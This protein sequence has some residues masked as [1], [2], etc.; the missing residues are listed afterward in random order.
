MFLSSITRL[1]VLILVV[2]PFTVNP[3]VI[4]TSPPTLSAPLMPAP[5]P[6]INA[7]VVVLELATPELAT[8][9]PNVPVLWPPALPVTAKLP[10]RLF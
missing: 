10:P 3:P 4:V 9:F 5:P 6:I 1:V 2:V 8:R 7:P